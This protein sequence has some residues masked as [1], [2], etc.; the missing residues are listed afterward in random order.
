MTERRIT[1]ASRKLSEFFNAC[2]DEELS[3]ADAAAKLD[4]SESYASRALAS[5]SGAGVV[6]RVSVY[7]LV[8]KVPEESIGMRVAE[9]LKAR[10]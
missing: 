7:R 6:E 5:L 8:R 4:I 2:P 9:A 3:A 10:A 1:Q